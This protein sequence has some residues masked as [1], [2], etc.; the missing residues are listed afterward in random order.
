MR[1]IK[2]IKFI[3]II[4][5][6]FSSSFA[7]N[8]EPRFVQL[9]MD[10][11]VALNLTYDIIQDSKGFL[12]FGTMYGLVKYDGENFITYKYN[13]EDSTSISFNDIISLLE[14]SKG[15]LWVGTWGGGLNKF[16]ISNKKFIRFLH[17]PINLQSVADNVIWSTCEDNK[18][19]IWIGTASQ[20][21]QSYDPSSGLF[22]KINL[23]LADST[24]VLPSIHCL[25]ADGNFLWI[26]HSKGLAKLNL[27]T[28][29]V[30]QFNLKEDNEKSAGTIIVHS[31]FKDSFGNLWVGTSSGLKKYNPNEQKFLQFDSDMKNSITSIAE[32]KNGFLWLGSNNGLIKLNSE[33][34]EYKKFTTSSDKNSIAGNFVNKVFSDKS[35]L[36]WISSYNRGITKAILTPA[37]FKRYPEITDDSK[38]SL[39]ENITALTGDNKGNIYIGSYG[40]K[41]Q[42]FNTDKE[43]N[44][45]ITIP[46]KEGSTIH[47]LMF[48]KNILWIGT[49]RTL[50]KYDLDKKNFEDITLRKEQKNEIEGNTITAFCFN[51]DSTLWIGT[52]NRGLLCY[53]LNQKDLKHYSL[54]M[55]QKP[56]Q[57]NFV[58]TIYSD[59]NND[60]WVGTYGGVYQLNPEGK[61]INSFVQLRNN[62]N[63]LSN[64]YVY[65]VLE[66]SKGNYWFGTASGLNEFDPKAKNFKHFYNKDGL[67]NDVIFGIVQEN[68]E[69]FWIST[70]KGISR[71]IPDKNSF[72]N[73]DEEDGLQG[74]VFN[75][76]VYFKSPAGNIYFGGLNGLTYFSPNE[77]KFSSFNPPIEITSI[78]IKD[79]DGDLLDVNPQFKEFDLEPNQNTFTIEFASLDF[80]NPDKNRYKYK[81][82]GLSDEWISLGSQNSVTFTKLEHGDYNFFLMGT[83][84]NGVWSNKTASFSFAIPPHFWQTWWFIPSIVAG[85]ILITLLTI[86]TVLS[87][88]V[89]RAVEIMQ[90][91][92]EESER[93]RKKTAIDFHDELGHRLTRISLLT[94]IIKRKIGFSFS[95]LRPL[96]DQI[97]ENS[98]KLYDG[99]KDFIWAIDPQKDSLYELVVRLKDFGDEIF[100]STEINFNVEGI[101]DELQNATL[102]MD[103]K[104]HLMLI[105]KEGMNNSLK[106]SKGTKVTLSSNLKED[107][108]ELVL[109]DDGEGFKPTGIL[110]GNGLKNM[111][112]RAATLNANI[113]IDSQPGAGTKLS[114]KGKFPIKSVNFN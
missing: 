14:D 88:K 83:N 57:A 91:R 66:D 99:T 62:P 53:N 17:D 69:T 65:S 25:L 43:K 47:S 49:N 33:T 1:I 15:N 101:S 70:S 2:R 18:G 97:S 89:K 31:I 42:V 59:S 24:N 64:N 8:S 9:P 54:V 11:G 111:K 84:S 21:L 37:N 34:G 20:G 106:H 113:K 67:P 46:D 6:L 74:D 39:K 26:G 48:N 56:E 7:Q 38:S 110:K 94:E 105:F 103:L 82:S 100:G 35:G 81:L 96:L 61:V 71:F 36:L 77:L 27:E 45:V 87:I 78:K 75:P 68:P 104:R 12:W 79:E 3:L 72:V 109:E 51:T 13:P 85:L 93:V 80:T 16:D 107:E 50:L 32:D 5:T 44:S 41:I 40:S 30:I 60:L 114:F 92:E 55:A 19:K 58:T 95:D 28:G 112:Q 52:Y 10:K 23:K 22:K 102:D 90:I 108:F 63:G 73:F 98:A 86:F 29:N 4:L 76:S